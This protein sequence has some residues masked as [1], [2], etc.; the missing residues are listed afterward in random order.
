[1]CIHV[2]VVRIYDYPLNL[3]I[4]IY[5]HF[6]HVSLYSLKLKVSKN[7][8]NWKYIAF[9]NVLFINVLKPVNAHAP[10]ICIYVQLFKFYKI[11]AVYVPVILKLF[12][13]AACACVMCHIGMVPL[14]NGLKSAA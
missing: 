3:S 11:E 14:H 12:V 1:M 6:I 2:H 5:L 13:H 10:F 9:E 8:S 4:P 7:I